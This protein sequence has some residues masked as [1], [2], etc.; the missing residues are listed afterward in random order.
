MG[1]FRAHDVLTLLR[2][3]F[4]IPKLLYVLRISPAFLSPLL[5]SWDLLLLSI[6]SKITNINIYP[7]DPCWLQA[8][9][10]VRSGGL[11]LRRAS[12]LAPTAFMGSADGAHSLMLDL[13]P[14]HL[15]ATSYEERKLALSTWKQD[16]PPETPVPT[17]P[18]NQKVWDR[19]K[20]DCLVDSI[21]TLS[22]D[23]ET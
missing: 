14:F 16:L 15:S 1:H 22:S 13:L 19:P 10:P 9:L 17:T 11:G 8:T 3:S 23:K 4:L 6:V 20:I 7:D 2:H 21:L 5:A 18:S 12:H